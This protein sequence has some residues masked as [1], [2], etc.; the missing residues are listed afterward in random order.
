[1]N[2]VYDRLIVLIF[3]CQNGKTSRGGRVSLLN[4]EVITKA[5]IAIQIMTKEWRK[6]TLLFD[7]FIRHITDH[8]RDA[9]EEWEFSKKPI[10]V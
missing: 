5:N 10:T 7:N 9:V 2:I 4:G 3:V 1:M 8:H 6:K